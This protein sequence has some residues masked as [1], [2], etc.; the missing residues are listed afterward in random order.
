MELEQTEQQ[1]PTSN[2]AHHSEWLKTI[3]PYAISRDV[4]NLEKKKPVTKILRSDTFR[5]KLEDVFRNV[6]DGK[7]PAIRRLQANIAP[8]SQIEKTIRQR[9][10]PNI[11]QQSCC[12]NSV[13]PINDLTSV[14]TDKYSIEEK[15]ARCKLASLYRVI[16]RMGWSFEIY[17]HISVSCV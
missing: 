9:N 17:N 2:L 1:T 5:G 16:E 13:I 15:R 6:V 8:A 10:Q 3:R 4:T 7:T 11:V 12:A 14:S